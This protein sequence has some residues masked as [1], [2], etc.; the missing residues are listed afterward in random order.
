LVWRSAIAITL[1]LAMPA[2][3]QDASASLQDMS[4]SS[5]APPVLLSL[6]DTDLELA[7]RAA[8]NGAAAFAVA[9]GNYFARDGVF[10]PLRDAVST[11]ILE[12]GF[13]TIVVPSL[14][15]ADLAAARLCLAAPGTELRIVPSTYGD[16]LTL[17]AV[18]DAR[19]FIYA[20]DPHLAADI[21]ITAAE[22]SIK[23]K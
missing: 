21:K 11:E 4:S 8:Y 19:D 12:E 20:Y 16:G 22:A 6:S 1:L 2:L 3:A 15:A 17:V 14:P 9:H 23:P 5:Q 13:S 7:V 10:G 18:T